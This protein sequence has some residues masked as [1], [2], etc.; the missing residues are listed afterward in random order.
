M[1]VSFTVGCSISRTGKATGITASAIVSP[2]CAS[3]MPATAAI[4]PAETS[5][6]S[7]RPKPSKVMSETMRN[8]FMAPS[9]LMCMTSDPWRITPFMTRPVAIRPLNVSADTVVTSICKG[10]VA[11]LGGSGMC[12]RMA[13]KTGVISSILEIS[14][15]S[16]ALPNLAAAYTKGKSAISSEAPSSK[17]N[18][19]VLSCT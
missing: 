7:L 19:R 15:S 3:G 9:R 2:I 14:G 5:V 12:F 18:S 13:S 4:S 8:F 11:S 1:I 16:P 10:F 6:T 17:N